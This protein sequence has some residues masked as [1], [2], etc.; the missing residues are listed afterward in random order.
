MRIMTIFG[1]RPEIIR[2]SVI[3]RVLDANSEHITV[4]TGQNFHENLSDIFFKEMGVRAPDVALGIRSTSFGDQIGKILS[5]LDEVLEKVQRHGKESLT[6]GEREI[7][8]KAAEIYKKR[9]RPG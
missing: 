2:L 1:T 7:L 9:R 8:L 4:H 6:D 5:K 3:M